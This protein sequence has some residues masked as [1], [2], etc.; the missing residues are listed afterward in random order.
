L[1]ETAARPGLGVT[2]PSISEPLRRF[3]IAARSAGV[4]I[5]SAE[6]IDAMRAVDVIGFSDRIALRDSLSLVVA[7][8]VEEK[9]IFNDCFE[10]YFQRNDFA[11]PKE[12][13]WRQPAEADDG[14]ED[15]KGG[16]EGEGGGPNPGSNPSAGGTGGGKGGGNPAGDK[17]AA[18]LLAEDRAGLAQAMEIAAE[19]IGLNKISFFTQTNLY[20]RRILERMGVRPVEREIEALRKAGGDA[21][22]ERADRLDQ[23]R[24]RLRDQVRDFVERHLALFAK[25]ENEKFREEF[26]KQAKLSNMD[27]RDLDRMRIIVRG[28]AKKLAE[29]YGR[30]RKKKNRGQLDTRKT[31]RRNMAWESIP[32]ITVWKQKKIDKPKVMVLCD[33]SG[34][35]AAMSQF[36]LMFLYSM[37]EALSNIRSFAF[38]GNLIEISE[39]LEREDI[40]P[41]IAK[42]LQQIG[43]GSSNYGNALL[44]FEEAYFPAVDSKTTVII[45]GDGRGNYNDPRTD[46]IM[47]LSERAKR[48]IW[49]NPEYRSSWG[50]GDSD[51][52]RYSPYCHV[53]TVC[54]TVRHLEH[55]V[56]DLLKASR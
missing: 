41:A 28:I 19:Q 26:L 17:L 7:K 6:S 16:A 46:I 2:G 24:E 45:L 43:F 32:F 44:D 48:L 10:L 23:G 4:R 35:V 21:P 13:G 38:A 51:I 56:T 42:I 22:N 53:M 34:S 30:N 1:S 31:I 47:R 12:P 39:I 15:D 40:E 49:L 3:L 9:Q 5:S 18:M 33:V 54:N 50:T 36:L 55:V 8:S 20:T 27:R 25:G 37:N 11:K 52:P 29:K 14:D